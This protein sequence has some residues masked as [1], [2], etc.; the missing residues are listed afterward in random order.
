MSNRMEVARAERELADSQSWSVSRVLIRSYRHIRVSVYMQ[1]IPKGSGNCD[2]EHPAS[3][4]KQ[5]IF[6][7]FSFMTQLIVPALRGN[8]LDKQT[9]TRSSI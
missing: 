7:P 9:N 2:V 5:S 3:P 1:I 4:D 8:V 6:L